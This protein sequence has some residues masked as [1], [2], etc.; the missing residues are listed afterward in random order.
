MDSKKK[1]YPLLSRSGIGPMGKRY[2]MLNLV[3]CEK[4]RGLC[5]YKISFP[6]GHLFP[7]GSCQILVALFYEWKNLYS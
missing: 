1:R 2:R 6:L 7:I 4:T 3:Y 5:G